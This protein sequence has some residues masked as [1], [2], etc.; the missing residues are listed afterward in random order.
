M[1]P[2]NKYQFLNLQ[3]Y[4]ESSRLGLFWLIALI[5]NKLKRKIKKKKVMKPS[6]QYMAQGAE[7]SGKSKYVKSRQF[8]PS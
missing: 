2:L 5:L 6:Q 1:V 8:L 7:K 4:S 3:D